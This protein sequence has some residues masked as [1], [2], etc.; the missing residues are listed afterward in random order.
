[1]VSSATWAQG[2]IIITWNPSLFILSI[3]ENLILKKEI[4]EGLEKSKVFNQTLFNKQTFLLAFL[5]HAN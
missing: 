3:L 5:P 1:M 2:V 4:N